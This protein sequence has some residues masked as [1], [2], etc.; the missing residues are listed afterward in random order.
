M[1]DKITKN[2]NLIYKQIKKNEESLK[3]DYLFHN[4]KT[5]V[6]K[7]MEKFDLLDSI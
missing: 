2:I 3:I 7:T 5:N 1:V 6:E 4:V